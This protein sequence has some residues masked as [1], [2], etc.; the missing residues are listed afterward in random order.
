MIRVT[1]V[2]RKNKDKV[3]EFRQDINKKNYKVFIY[4]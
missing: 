2:E 3:P 4:L 1:T